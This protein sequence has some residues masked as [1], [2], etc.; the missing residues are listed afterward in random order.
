MSEKSNLAYFAG[1]SATG[2]GENWAK[3]NIVKTLVSPKSQPMQVSAKYHDDCKKI[4]P[5]SFLDAS[6]NF[7]KNFDA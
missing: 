2:F 3:I 1:V 5:K 7:Y 4:V 6:G